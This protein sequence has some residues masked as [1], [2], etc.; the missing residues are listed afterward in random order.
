MFVFSVDASINFL[1]VQM[2]YAAGSMLLGYSSGV[3]SGI[4]LGISE[5]SFAELPPMSGSSAV[6]ELTVQPRRGQVLISSSESGRWTQAHVIQN[7]ISV[8]VQDDIKRLQTE[9]QSLSCSS[10]ICVIGKAYM[11][12]YDNLEISIFFGT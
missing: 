1:Y 2:A 7:L 3:R 10:L 4:F 9:M 5:A 8:L 11:L 12:N 6:L